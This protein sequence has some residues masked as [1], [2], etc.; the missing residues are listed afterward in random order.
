[1][2]HPTL[3]DRS[4]YPRIERQHP[5]AEDRGD[6]GQACGVEHVIEQSKSSSS[7]FLLA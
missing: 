2:F 6:D 4:Q 1:L 7:Q 3:D 5:D